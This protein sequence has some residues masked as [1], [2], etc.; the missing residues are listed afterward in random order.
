MNYE[1]LLIQIVIGI[2]V[3][4]VLIKLYQTKRSISYE[5]RLGMYSINSV[6]DNEL[7]FFDQVY[8][9]FYGLIKSFSKILNKFKGQKIKSR[10]YQKYITYVKKDE[11]EPI[12]LLTIKYLITILS[13]IMSLIFSLTRYG[14]LNYLL[15]ISS[16]LLYYLLD[17]IL[18]INFKRKKHS[19]AEDLLKAIMIM[20]NAFKTGRN[21]VQAIETVTT[22]LTG[23]IADEFKK[24]LVDLKY[25]LSYDVAFKRFYQRVKIDDARYIATS[26]ILVNKTGGSIKNIFKNIE[27]TIM[28]RKKL[29][30]ELKSLTSAARMM[31]KILIILPIIM[32]IIILLLNNNYFKPFFNNPVGILFLFIALILFV[33]YIV[34]VRKILRVKIKWRMIR[35]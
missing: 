22:E 24:I 30:N 14:N 2:L 5:K 8:L 9:F 16:L 32:V 4:L 28:T 3:G 17:I 1:I 34:I 7:S 33:S 19:I 10:K 26:L 15:I 13:L 35:V 21:I 6:L 27:N 31:A 12:D 20:N 18:Y 29:E 25:G 23:P 11:Y